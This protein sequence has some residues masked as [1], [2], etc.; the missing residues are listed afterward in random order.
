MKRRDGKKGKFGATIVYKHTIYIYISHKQLIPFLILFET[1]IFFQ[2]FNVG[3][4]KL[5]ILWI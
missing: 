1:S 3:L 5:Y 2:L 4:P